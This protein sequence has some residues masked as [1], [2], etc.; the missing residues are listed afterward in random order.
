MRT[1]GFRTLGCKLNQA[2][3]AIL[4]GMF[5]Q[6]GYELVPAEDSPDV[7]LIHTCTVTARTDAK[8]RQFIH[9]VL[10]ENPSC[11]VIVAGC[12]AQIG[13]EEIAKIPGV[14]YI[15]GTEDKFR[16]FD[17]FPGPGKRSQPLIRVSPIQGNFAFSSPVF[18]FETHTRAFLK[19]QSGCNRQCAYCIVPMARGP[20][21]SE[22]M[23]CILKN[24][25]LF[26]QKGYK[27]LV[28]TGTHIG[29]YGKDFGKTS[30]LAQLLREL[31]KIKGIGRIRLSSLD[32]DEVTDELLDV[33]AREE[34]ICRHFHLSL[35]S[36]SDAILHAMKRSYTTKEVEN[37]IEKLVTRFGILGLGADFITGFPGETDTLFEETVRFVEKLPFTYLHV[38]PF[39]V[40]KGTLAEKLPNGVPP[41]IRMERAKVLRELGLQ[42]KKAFASQFLGKTVSALFE[43]KEK[44]HWM[45]G[46]TPEYLRV[47]VPSHPS[48]R[49]QI[50]D[51]KVKE[52]SKNGVRGSVVNL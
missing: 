8:C 22:P 1:V 10:K 21:R 32:P 51:V 31:L 12:Y 48:L 14:D 16:L 49:N 6:K 9:R 45:Y 25:E 7:V 29:D 37:L 3:T 24:A 50:L 26:V 33:I 11:T 13:A 18:P 52:I 17:F 15:V 5:V 38:F 41:S 30:L 47:E 36:G 23:E 4:A 20:G 35:Q 34:R 40:R 28:I 46:L 27:E 42:K 19:I 44:N 39:S 43:A 2:E